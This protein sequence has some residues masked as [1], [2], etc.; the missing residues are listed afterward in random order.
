MQP[1]IRKQTPLIF[2]IL[3]YV[4]DLELH[5]NLNCKRAKYAAFI[6]FKYNF[7]SLQAHFNILLAL[8]FVQFQLFFFLGSISATFTKCANSNYLFL[9]IHEIQPHREK[10]SLS[11]GLY[12]Y[13]YICGLKQD[14]Q[15]QTIWQFFTVLQRPNNASYADYLTDKNLIFQVLFCLII[16]VLDGKTQFSIHTEPIFIEQLNVC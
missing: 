15:H 8:D 7:A 5:C 10:H 2:F 3:H 9:F 13:L 12:C 1:V 11:P 4:T 14:Q 16:R 6:Q